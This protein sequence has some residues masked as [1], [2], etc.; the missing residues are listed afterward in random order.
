MT[1]FAAGAAVVP[2]VR[3]VS[4]WPLVGVGTLVLTATGFADATLEGV[5]A[6]RFGLL[7]SAGVVSAAVSAAVD[8]AEELLDPLPLASRLRQGMRQ[9][10]QLVVA[11]VVALVALEVTGAGG[12]GGLLALAVVAV[13][14]TLVV[15]A[16]L[17]RPAAGVPLAWVALDLFV[18]PRFEALAAWREHPWAVATAGV[19]LAVLVHHLLDRLPGGLR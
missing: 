15:P 10:S 16:R 4:W 3:S 6:G 9:A 13:S 12:G 18:G 17:V 7:G 1:P 5:A 14:L 19:A 11:L 2:V 8:P